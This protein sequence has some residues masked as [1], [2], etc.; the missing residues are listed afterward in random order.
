MIEILNASMLTR[1]RDTG[2]L[3]ADIL[4]TLR[5]RSTVGTNLLDIDR[6]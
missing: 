5:S 6:W 1:A 2:A 4:Q 3:V